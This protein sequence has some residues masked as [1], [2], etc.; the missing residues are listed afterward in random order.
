MT[1]FIRQKI[2]AEW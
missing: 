2:Q 1:T